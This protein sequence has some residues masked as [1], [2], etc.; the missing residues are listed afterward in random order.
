MTIRNIITSAAI[1]AFLGLAGGSAYANDF[2][3]QGD[4]H[5]DLGFTVSWNANHPVT[6]FVYM[7]DS[8]IDEVSPASANANYP[9]TEYVY[10]GDSDVDTGE[11]LTDGFAQ[12]RL[13]ELFLENFKTN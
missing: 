4:S 2:D 12:A 3:S 1:A 10:N 6:E 13:P 7:G 8:D 9:G 5:I 11:I